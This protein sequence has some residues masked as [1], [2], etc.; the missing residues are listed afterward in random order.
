M[1]AREESLKSP[2]ERIVMSTSGDEQMH[3]YPVLVIGRADR[4]GGAVTRHLLAH[5]LPVRLWA[6]APDSQA[7]LDL[8]RSGADLV[9]GSLDDSDV[10]RTLRGSGALFFVLDQPDAGPDVRLRRGRAVAD[11]AKAA[12]V[13]RIVYATA[14][15]PD[16]HL[17]SCDVGSEVEAHL[18][19]LDLRA[20]V[21]R[22][23][24][25]MEEIPWYWL[26]RLDGELVISTPFSPEERLP[27][28][29]ID[30]IGALAALAVTSPEEFEG[31]TVRI[32]GDVE[33]MAG[34][35]RELAEALGEPVKAVE[36]QVE[37]VFML[38]PAGEPAPDLARLRRIHP[39]LRTVDSWLHAGRWPAADR[40]A[41]HASRR[42]GGGVGHGWRFDAEVAMQG[43]PVHLRPRGR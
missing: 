6:D 2:D 17:V 25:V 30:D 8:Q 41:A 12:G 31:G 7:A 9:V 40:A 36:V 26:S 39:G 37:G 27:M 4:Q 16:H 38:M 13:S 14:T 23:V 22:P 42:V 28:I 20:T 15:A 34:V 11:A 32:A 1:R 5:G 19:S 3:H 10:E 18:R 21:L 33:S 24:T 35:A 29:C 43:L